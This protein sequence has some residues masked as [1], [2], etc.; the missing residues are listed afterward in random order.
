MVLTNKHHV[1]LD[2]K[3]DLSPNNVF[4]IHQRI[5]NMRFM[6]LVVIYFQ[7][8]YLSDAGDVS[9]DILRQSQLPPCK[10]CKVL[11]NS[12]KKVSG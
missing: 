1:H 4:V 11:V 5:I 2:K 9:K 7:L 8:I 3:H 6:L 12:F 10:A